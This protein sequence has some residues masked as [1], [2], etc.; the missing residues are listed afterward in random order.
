[1]G[2][3]GHHLEDVIALLRQRNTSTWCRP[4]RHARDPSFASAG[5]SGQTDVLT[6]PGTQL[7]LESRRFRVPAFNQRQHDLC[8][9]FHLYVI[10][11]TWFSNLEVYLQRWCWCLAYA[12]YYVC[13][14]VLVA[15]GRPLSYTLSCYRSTSGFP[16]GRVYAS[17]N[18]CKI[19]AVL[20][21]LR[22]TFALY[23]PRR[24]LRV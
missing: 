5:C 9:Y 7:V 11:M 19:L 16:E 23:W 4:W 22:N 3:T 20:L 6:H 14:L 13:R 24:H 18:S 10:N 1:M 8:G 15:R 17:R 2:A 12:F 21:L